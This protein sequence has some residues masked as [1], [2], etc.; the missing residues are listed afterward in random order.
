MKSDLVD[1]VLIQHHR[2]EKA[3]LVS[4]TGDRE[5]AIWLPL[6]AIEIENGRGAG[7]VTVTLPERLA[8]DKGLI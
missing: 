6:A 3:V 8:L 4:E 1:L 7:V 5:K 2:T